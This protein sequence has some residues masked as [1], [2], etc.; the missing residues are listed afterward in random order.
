MNNINELIQYFRLFQLHIIEDRNEFLQLEFKNLENID[1][2]LPE[3]L[4]QQPF[5]EYNIFYYEDYFQSLSE[6]NQE[7]KETYDGQ[8]DTNEGAVKITIFKN[9]LLSHYNNLL[10]NSYIYYDINNFCKDSINFDT[11]DD[12]NKI[13]VFTIN[14]IPKDIENEYIRYVNI[15]FIQSVSNKEID[16]TTI[17]LFNTIKENFE[18]KNINFYADI[19]HFWYFESTELF[20]CKEKCVITFFNLISNKIIKQNNEYIIKGHHNLSFKL[21]L[22]DNS[23]INT[24]VIIDLMNFTIDGDRHLDKLLILRNVITTYINNYS[25]FDHFNN[26]SL[27]ILATADHHFEL[28]I[29]NEIKIFIEQKNQLLNE[30]LLLT[31]QISGQ[32]KETSSHLR[33]LVLTLLGAIIVSGIPAIIETNFNKILWNII[34]V[35][36]IFY[37]LTNIFISKKLLQQ[38]KNNLIILENYI[39]S[40]S[41]NS[42]V[43]FDYKS[44]KEKFISNEEQNFM[45]TLNVYNITIY[46][47]VVISIGS[48]IYLNKDVLCFLLKLA[49]SYLNL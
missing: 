30:T 2:K 43:G 41:S 21:D 19:P 22:S 39:S 25:N 23:E 35:F 32:T 24:N 18:N 33:N 26:Q 40:V 27:Q 29:Q 49:W 28:Y 7:I 15:E 34:I 31:K 10:Q 8:L 12:N 42:L 17:S 13:N 16:S 47:L 36:A 11:N 45:S 37:L 3:F 38:H 1:D 9:K 6:F 4:R 5:V 46:A 48:L 14:E 44:L 20:A